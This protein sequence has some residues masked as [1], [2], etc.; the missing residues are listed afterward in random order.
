MRASESLKSP[1]ERFIPQNAL[2]MRPRQHP[3]LPQVTP[4]P[5][6]RSRAGN[7]FADFM[8]GRPY[9]QHSRVMDNLNPARSNE[10]Q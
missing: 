2:Q 5:P 6:Q 9:S 7:L 1:R 3:H 8:E 4:L 10:E